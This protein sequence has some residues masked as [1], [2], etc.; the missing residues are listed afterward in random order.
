MRIRLA[1]LAMTLLLLGLGAPACRNVAPTGE[2]AVIETNYG[3]IVIDFFPNDAPQTVANF[4]EL[5]RQGFYDGTKFFGVVKDQG[6]PAAIFGGDPN[7]INGDPSTWGHGQPG[8]RKIPGE[9]SKTLTHARGAVSMVRKQ[10]DENSATSQFFI[11]VAPYPKRDGQNA[12]FARVI[13]GMNV[14]DAIARAP[15]FPKTERPLDP[16]VVNRIYLVKRG[17]VEV[18][19]N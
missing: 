12:I 13:D 10:D 19:R 16:V 7:T 4:Q 11:C 18:S 1:F 14:V 15:L 3:K 9:F 6:K 8:Q 17:E 5:A 2:L